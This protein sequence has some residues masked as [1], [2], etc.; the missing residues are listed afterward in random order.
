MNHNNS[1]W[2]IGLTI[3]AAVTSLK[4]T[5]RIR[6]EMTQL[7]DGL[8]SPL[9]ATFD[10]RGVNFAIFTDNATGVDLCLFDAGGQ[11]EIARYSLPQRTEGIWH[12][13]VNGLSPG[14]LYGYRVYGP[15]E[16]AHGHRFNPSKLVI[17]PYA[18]G[19]AGPLIWNDALYGYRVGDNHPDAPPDFRDSARYIPKCV[20]EAPFTDWS[21]VTVRRDWRDT[22][23][24]EAHVKGLTKLHPDVPPAIRGT[25]DAL[26]HPAVIDHL[27]KLG[28]TAVELLPIHAFVDDHFLVKKGLRNYWGYSTLSYFTPESRYLSES[29]VQGLRQAVRSLHEAGIEV[30]LDVVFNH[31]AEGNEF[32]PTLSFKGVDNAVY[33]KLPSEDL[34]RYWDA[35]GTGN[36][37]DVAHPQVLQLVMDS[38]RY[39]VQAY[40]IDGF[41]FDLASAL[42]RQP[43]DFSPNSGFLAAVGQ[44][45][46]LRQTKLIA[47]PWDLGMDGYRLGGFPR[48]WAEW[49]DRYRDGV[50]AF[51]RGNEGQ[52][53]RLTEGLT[54]SREVF[55]ASGRLPPASI[56]YVTSHDGFTLEDV[57]SYEERHNYRNGE[58]NRDG[59]RHNLTSNHGV[60]GPTNKPE[61]LA[62]RA[63]QKRNFLATLFLSIGTPMLLMGDAMSRTQNGNN[64]AYCQ[65][66][67]IGWVDWRPGPDPALQTF[68]ENLS[69]IRRT[70]RV[71]RRKDF[72]DG[73]H[74]SDNQLRDVYWLAPEGREMDE[75][76]WRAP[77]RRTI[78]CQIGNDE[79]GEL[80]LLMIL[81][82]DP[83]PIGFHLAGDFPGDAWSPI[84]DTG[85]PDGTPLDRSPLLAGGSRVVD[86][87]SFLLFRQSPPSS[88]S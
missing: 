84:L 76:D 22:V 28:I 63:R 21:D 29:G 64:N 20:V 31:T 53:P 82:A 37:V 4:A 50:R 62:L 49:N 71:F 79:E 5:L 6:D 32:G 88:G 3:A 18:R 81:N 43:H 36:T 59:H 74:R 75:A 23:I 35:T 2:F 10:G 51:W 34:R 78:G 69:A 54:G 83:D 11:H 15:Y 7:D 14:Q 45:P 72:L 65:D 42:C 87:R 25:Y 66:N 33:Y 38:L 16:P 55:G 61:I 58:N 40:G 70:Y 60:E 57:V 9:G 17:D 39:W 8:P 26:G 77:H 30:I 1:V 41:R 85:S 48:G 44:D 52:L 73:L 68:T 27:V 12:G 80:R 46:I 86:G 13:Y 56:N 47:E 24:Y 67:D 19:L